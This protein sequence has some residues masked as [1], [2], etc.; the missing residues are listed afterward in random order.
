MGSGG[1]G[2]LGRMA[3][4]DIRL[5]AA[6]AVLNFN[7]FNSGYINP[8][9][10]RHSI[11]VLCG[12]Q[13]LITTRDIG[14]AASSDAFEIQECIPVL[15]A[16]SEL[17]T[18][19]HNDAIFNRHEWKSDRTSGGGGGIGDYLPGSREPGGDSRE[20]LGCRPMQSS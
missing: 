7:P 4:W 19:E 8:L 11:P 18:I 6:I 16:K 9:S 3:G 15:L 5:G 2:G 17:G 12:K 13:Q 10:K 20:R 14:A 1:P